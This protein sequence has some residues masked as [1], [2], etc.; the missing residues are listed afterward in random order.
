MSGSDHSI[1]A[2]ENPSQEIA[3]LL[4]RASQAATSADLHTLLEHMLALMMEICQNRK[5][6]V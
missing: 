5:S 1:N 4:E 6:V 3:W 2:E